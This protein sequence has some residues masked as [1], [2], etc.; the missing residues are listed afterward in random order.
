MAA[1]AVER[2]EALIAGEA[3]EAPGEPLV[4]VPELIVRESTA[5]RSP[6]RRAS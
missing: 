1:A 5:R 2:L 3:T 6:A 4:I